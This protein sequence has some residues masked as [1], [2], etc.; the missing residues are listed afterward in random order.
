MEVSEQIEMVGKHWRILEELRERERQ[1]KEKDGLKEYYV[2]ELAKKL[3]WSVPYMSESLSE[4]ETAKLVKSREPR[5]DRRK[6]YSLTDRGQEIVEFFKKLEQPPEE[7]KLRD[8]ESSELERCLIALD[9]NK[10]SND[11]IRIKLAYRFFQLCGQGYRVWK[12]KNVLEIFK[13]MVEEPE[14]FA[15]Q[16]GGRFMIAFE[17]A[18]RYMMEDGQLS[19]VM[20]HLYKEIEKGIRNSNL[21]DVSR[22]FEASLMKRIFRYNKEKQDDILRITLDIALENGLSM[23]T[24]T[25]KQVKDIIQLCLTPELEAKRDKIFGLLLE[26]ANSS[27]PAIRQKAEDLIDPFITVG[28]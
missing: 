27:D 18:L 23:E 2:A 28:R 24:H 6:Y 20:K 8:I 16:V 3:G 19:W 9:T 13:K 25:Y 21:D 5:D 11:N 15:G 4:L 14:T 12:H 17:E 10:L 1:L 7:L 26:K 22:S